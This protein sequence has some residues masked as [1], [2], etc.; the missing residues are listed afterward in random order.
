MTTGEWYAKFGVAQSSS[1]ED[2]TEKSD[3]IVVLSPDNPEQHEALTALVLKSG[4]LVYVYKTFAN[5]RAAA[6]RMFNLA[7]KHAIKGYYQK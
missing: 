7:E 5:N 6:E 4:K 2:L 1:Q 3:C